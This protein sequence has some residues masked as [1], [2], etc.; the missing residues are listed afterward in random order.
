MEQNSSPMD[1]PDPVGSSEGTGLLREL[2]DLLMFSQ[3][4]PEKAAEQFRLRAEDILS[5]T[6]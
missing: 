6:K 1:P 5:H 3:I 2:Y 4:T